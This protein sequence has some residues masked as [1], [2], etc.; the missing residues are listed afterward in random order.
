MKQLLLKT[1]A[2]YTE[3]MEWTLRNSVLGDDISPGPLRSLS[4][5]LQTLL[6]RESGKGCWS[7]VR[8]QEQVKT[9]IGSDNTNKQTKPK[10]C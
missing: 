7:S 2:V 8:Q 6:L 10:H 9:F 5:W 1:K 4:S 3:L